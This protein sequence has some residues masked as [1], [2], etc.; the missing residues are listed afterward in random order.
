MLEVHN[1]GVIVVLAREQRLREVRRMNICKWMVMRVPSPEAEVETADRCVV[2][3]DDDD[4]LV[5]RPELNRVCNACVNRAILCDGNDL[6]TLRTYV[7]RVP[8]N[9]DIGVLELEEPL[10]RKVSLG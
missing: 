6:L 8:Q 3:V 7:V 10:Q 9:H 1:P 5:V 4:F 2:V